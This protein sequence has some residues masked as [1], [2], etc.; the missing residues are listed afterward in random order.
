MMRTASTGSPIAFATS[1]EA[2]TIYGRS[3]RM[4]W[5]KIQKYRDDTPTGRNRNVW[6]ALSYLTGFLN[7]IGVGTANVAPP[8]VPMDTRQG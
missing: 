6:A 7:H 8:P 3:D 4:L 5:H 2:R 1:D